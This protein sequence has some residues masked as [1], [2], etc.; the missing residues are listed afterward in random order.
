MATIRCGQ[1]GA[2]HESV[3]AVKLCYASPGTQTMLAEDPITT[4]QMKFLAVLRTERGLVTDGI[5][6]LSK[7][8]ASGEI[9]RH[10]SPE[11][12]AAKLAH[13]RQNLRKEAVA[14]FRDELYIGPGRPTGTPS[15]FHNGQPVRSS[16][17][18]KSEW[19]RFEDIPQGHYAV[20]SLTGAQDLDFFR[21]DRPETGPYQGRYFMKRVIGGKPDTPI[22]GRTIL[23]AMRA[24][25]KADPAK[26]ALLYGQEIGR[27]YKCNRHLTD[28]TSRALGIGPDC[29]SK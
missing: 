8:D 2:L 9:K 22:R 18:P 11:G 3:T 20:R 23:E 13:E 27:C 26:A 5:G 6:K 16:S 10:L 24:I 17:A 1:C 21:V 19:E 15:V 29:R 4:N 14:E 28:E 7:T 12:K 25:R